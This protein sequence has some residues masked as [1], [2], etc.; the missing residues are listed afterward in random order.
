MAFLGAKQRQRF[1]LAD[2]PR[3]HVSSL[4]QIEGSRSSCANSFVAATSSPGRTRFG[5]EL[6]LSTWAQLNDRFAEMNIEI[7]ANDIPARG[8]GVLATP[9]A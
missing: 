8:W 6:S 1:E 7:V 2:L 9:S 5:A 3:R 4:N